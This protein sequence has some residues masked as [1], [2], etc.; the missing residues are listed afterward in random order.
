MSQPTAVVPDKGIRK[1]YN[2]TGGDLVQGICVKLTASPTVH[3]EI[4]LA[5]AATDPCYGVLMHD[6]ADTEY[7]DCQ[8]AGIALA[9]ASTTVAAAARVTGT[10]GGK[11][12]AASAAN[13]VFGVA[14]TAG[15]TDTLHEVELTGPGGAEMPG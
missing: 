15:A 5:D 13:A 8:V 10:T 7:G 12:V 4:E 3:S 14:V 11:T 9:L 1:I 6:V 2:G